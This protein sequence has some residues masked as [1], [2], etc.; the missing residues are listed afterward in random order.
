MVPARYD[1][2]PPAARSGVPRTTLAAAEAGT[3]DLGVTRLAVLAEVA[4]FR[5]TVLD[6]DGREVAGMHPDGPRDVTGRRLP[7]HLDTQHTDEVGDRWAHTPRRPQ[8]WFTSGLDRAARDRGRARSGT[9]DD[10]DVPVP[11]DSPRERAEARLDARWRTSPR[12]GGGASWP[13]S[14]GTSR[15][16]G[17]APARRRATRSTTARARRGTPPAARAAATRADPLLP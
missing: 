2:A 6:A 10:H 3:R 9:P 15:T 8:P 5:L 4:G 7:A 13:A 14:S 11:G 12:S 1:P 16:A 17:P